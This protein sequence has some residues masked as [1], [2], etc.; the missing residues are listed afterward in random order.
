MVHVYALEALPEIQPRSAEIQPRTEIQPRSAESPTPMLTIVLILIRT[1]MLTPLLT[2]T[3][4]LIRILILILT[5]ILTLTL[6][7]IR[8]LLPTRQPLHVYELEVLPEMQPRSDESA[9]AFARRAAE[10]IAS[11]FG[12]P[13]T[14]ARFYECSTRYEHQL[15]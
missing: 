4:S 7:L 15:M 8:M 5:S 12:Q 14:Q 9:E 6:S 13:A 3:L 1:L 10:E 2:L 11:R